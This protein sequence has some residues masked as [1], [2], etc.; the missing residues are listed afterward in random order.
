M[1]LR[2]Q[3]VAQLEV[4]VDLAVVE[5]LQLAIGHRLQPRVREVDDRESQMAEADAVVGEDAATVR[6]AV[7]E[8]VEPALDGR[9]LRRTAEI[10]DAAE[11]AHQRA[12]FPA[13]A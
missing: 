10:D 3:L 1:P 12:R 13:S 2:P 5:Q 11:S 9:A 4:V 6:P 8:L 7:G